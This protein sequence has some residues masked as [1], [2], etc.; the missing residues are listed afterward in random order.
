MRTK[1][2]DKI[3][4]FESKVNGEING[5]ING[6]ESVLAS[7]INVEPIKSGELTSADVEN[8]N[9]TQWVTLRTSYANKLYYLLVGEIVGLFLIIACV[10]WKCMVLDPWIVN[11]FASSV[12]LQSFAL[13][14]VI[15][16]NLFDKNETN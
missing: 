10:G 11:I 12:I 7:P 5:E 3:A 9:K 16:K 4:S 1:L 8:F 6:E 15:V 2:I 14:Q 13:V